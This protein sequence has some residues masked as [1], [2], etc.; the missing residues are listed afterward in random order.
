MIIEGDVHREKIVSFTLVSASQTHELLIRTDVEL[1]DELREHLAAQGFRLPEGAARSVLT[2]IITATAGNPAAW[3]AVGGVIV[4]FL[5]RHRGKVHRF[6]VE[7]NSVSIEGYSAKE[8]EALAE[9]LRA[10]SRDRHSQDE[11]GGPIIGGRADS[12]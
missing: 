12:I 5:R 1:A 10:M 4:S 8:A 2:E 11:T 7:G 6:E 9:S 3:T